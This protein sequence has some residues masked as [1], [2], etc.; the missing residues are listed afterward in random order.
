MIRLT[1]NKRLQLDQGI[2]RWECTGLYGCV[3]GYATPWQALNAYMRLRRRMRA[4]E[5]G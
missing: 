1:V 2:T 3:S 5:Q 4:H